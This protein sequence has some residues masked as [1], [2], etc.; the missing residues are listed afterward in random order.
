MT[1]ETEDLPPSAPASSIGE[2]A[3]APEPIA[4]PPPTEPIV[5]AAVQEMAAPPEPPSVP[6]APQSLPR[7]G[8]PLVDDAARARAYATIVRKREKSFTRIVELAQK[9]G[10][11]RN[12]DVA[13]LLHVS[14]ATASRYVR[15]LISRGQL[16]AVGKGRARAYGLTVR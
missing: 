15:A 16:T 1:D 11:V 8:L 12:A 9:K 14:D 6:S 7:A 3:P 4:E 2:E 5:P 10:K 13:K